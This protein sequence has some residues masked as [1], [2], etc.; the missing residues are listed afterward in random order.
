MNNQI[1][2]QDIV[3][4]IKRKELAVFKRN[5]NKIP[6]CSINGTFDD[7]TKENVCWWTNGFWGGLAWQMYH[8]TGE[9]I[10]LTTAENLEQTLDKNLMTFMGMDHDSGFRWL[11]T[12]IADYRMTKNPDSL[13]RGM[14]AADN[15]AGRFNH[16]GKFIRAW[17]SGETLSERAGWAIIDCMMNLPLLY[18]AYEETKDPRYLQIA[19]MHADTTMKYFIRE[20][21]SAKHIVEFNPFTGAYMQSH[22]GQGYAH[23]SSW[24]RGQ[25]WAIYGFTLSYIHTKEEKYLNCAKK[26]ADYFIENM[27]S[28]SLIPVDFKQPEIP[29]YEDSTAAAI[30]ACGL[31]EISRQIKSDENSHYL[32]AAIRILQALIENRADWSEETD[33]ILS[34]CAE[35]YHR[36]VKINSMLYADYFFVEAIWKLADLE[37]FIW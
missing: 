22:G 34:H 25:G 11:P 37:F 2:L 3:E 9:A 17:N 33:S 29:H 6:Y 24:T 31:I 18:W 20:D 15:M 36:N 14:L 5:T 1:W 23:G 13:N 35:A 7:M 16:I 4:K 19:A 27:P 26:V 10:Y 28:S 32:H 8:A 12:A 21:G 30:T